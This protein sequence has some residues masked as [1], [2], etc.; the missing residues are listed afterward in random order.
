MI[1][2]SLFVQFILYN[3]HKYHPSILYSKHVPFESESMDNMKRKRSDSEDLDATSSNVSNT[4]T[5][6]STNVP[7]S[8]FDNRPKLL[9]QHEIDE[10]DFSKYVENLQKYR[11]LTLLLREN[12]SNNTKIEHIELFYSN[13]NAPT[14]YNIEKGGLFD[15]WIN[16]F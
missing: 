12:I 3:K 11:L 14:A 7:R 5:K 8:G 1:W 9:Y 10:R 15:D 6:V 16:T 2:K 4:T 13:K